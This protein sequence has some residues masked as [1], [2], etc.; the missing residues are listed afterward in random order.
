M[1]ARGWF[2]FG[3]VACA[4]LFVGVWL[5]WGHEAAAVAGGGAGAALATAQALEAADRKRR[6]REAKIK[7]IEDKT[8]SDVA[9][10]DAT[11]QARRA[12]PT[13]ADLGRLRGKFGGKR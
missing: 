4:A 7:T 8:A 2:V 5:V 13:K 6:E 12:N 9:D 3:V 11:G 1:S 10:I